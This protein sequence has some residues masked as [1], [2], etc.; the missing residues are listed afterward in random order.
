MGFGHD[1]VRRLPLWGISQV[2]QEQIDFEFPTKAV[3]ERWLSQGVPD[4]EQINLWF[5]DPN[6]VCLRAI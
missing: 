6:T 1:A 3:L 5:R 2:P 4:L